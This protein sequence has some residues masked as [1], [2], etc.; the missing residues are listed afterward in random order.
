MVAEE[1]G[2]IG[3]GVCIRR[4]R[5]KSKLI[6]REREKKRRLPTALG[7]SKERANANG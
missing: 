5:I 4:Q 6:V 2:I 1:T 7:Q 3:C